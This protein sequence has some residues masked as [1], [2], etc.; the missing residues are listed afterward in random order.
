MLSEAAAKGDNSRQSS[1]KVEK[2]LCEHIEHE[3]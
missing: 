2:Q 1:A 3:D